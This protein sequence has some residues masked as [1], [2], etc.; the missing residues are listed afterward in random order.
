M[1]IIPIVCIFESEEEQSDI[2]RSF[3]IYSK[4]HMLKTVELDF[5]HTFVLRVLGCCNYLTS[6]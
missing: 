1:K 2:Q 5:E 4:S 6:D 3:V